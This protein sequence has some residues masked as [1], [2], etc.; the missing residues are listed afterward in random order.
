[1]FVDL[2]RL[3]RFLSLFR[4]AE[5]N[6]SGLVNTQSEYICRCKRQV[7]TAM[8]FYRTVVEKIWEEDMAAVTELSRLDSIERSSWS[9]SGVASRDRF[10]DSRGSNY[11]PGRLI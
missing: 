2:Y 7:D 4:P 3:Q 11:A 10:L 5:P 8:S 6:D 9:G 1:M